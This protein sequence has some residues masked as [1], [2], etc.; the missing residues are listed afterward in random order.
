ML[1][2]E[3][4]VV[5]GECFCLQVSVDIV[6]KGEDCLVGIL[7]C[8]V[9]VLVVE[10]GG[11]Q[12]CQFVINVYQFVDLWCVQFMGDV[13]KLLRIFEE[14]GLGIVSCCQWVLII[15]CFSR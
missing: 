11:V 9:R 6:F 1:L 15:E 3:V 4:K 8:K 13:D 7:W 14:F 10:V 2:G 12:I 5:F